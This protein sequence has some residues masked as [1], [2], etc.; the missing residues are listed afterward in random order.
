MKNNAPRPI[1]RTTLVLGLLFLSIVDC[2]LG[3]ANAPIYDPSWRAILI[4]MLGLWIASIP[5]GRLLGVLFI[6]EAV[7]A[8]SIF[9]TSGIIKLRVFHFVFSVLALT[10][11]I[12]IFMRRKVST[13]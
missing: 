9:Y 11:A 10:L 8:A 6:A 5:G 13:S 7:T 12:L 2:I 1:E 4:V 3:L